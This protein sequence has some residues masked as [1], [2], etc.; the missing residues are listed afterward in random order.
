VQGWSW[1]AEKKSFLTFVFA[2]KNGHILQKYRQCYMGSNGCRYVLVCV[3]KYLV[4]VGLFVVVDVTQS[5][6]SG[7][8]TPTIYDQIHQ[9]V[10]VLLRHDNDRICITYDT[11]HAVCVRFH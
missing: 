11:Y 6:A 5:P 1:P 3:E 8:N 10:L 9:Y 4:Y 2:A 7:S